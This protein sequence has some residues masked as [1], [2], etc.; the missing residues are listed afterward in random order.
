M[1]FLFFVFL[2]G[3]VVWF[4]G[5][6][7]SANQPA[8]IKLLLLAVSLFFFPVGPLAALVYIWFSET[9][10]EVLTV[11]A[12]GTAPV[13]RRSGMKRF[14][15]ILAILAGIIVATGQIISGAVHILDGVQTVTPLL[16]RY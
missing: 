11:A 3:V 4:V 15:E 1:E 2:L 13:K 14:V 10:G 9:R 7:V 8:P 16:A 6:I 5:K 12:A